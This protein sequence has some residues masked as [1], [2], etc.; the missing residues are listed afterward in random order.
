MKG[1]AIASI[2]IEVAAGLLLIVDMATGSKF[3][4]CAGGMMTLFA[5]VAFVLA[6]VV[7]AHKEK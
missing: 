3:A 4:A 7:L 2:V 1:L 6:V 5:I